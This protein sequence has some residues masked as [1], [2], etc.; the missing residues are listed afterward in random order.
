MKSAHLRRAFEIAIISNDEL[1]ADRL[2]SIATREGYD[3]LADEMLAQYRLA[4]GCR[5]EEEF[6]S[7]QEELA[8][9]YE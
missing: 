1:N 8:L 4:F 3:E 5:V 7:L 6:E 9:S 2:I